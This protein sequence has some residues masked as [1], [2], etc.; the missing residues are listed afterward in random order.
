MMVRE[1]TS[2]CNVLFWD[3]LVPIHGMC[4]HVYCTFIGLIL[5]GL[6]E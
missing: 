3:V 5:V 2:N 4:N 6:V 1:C